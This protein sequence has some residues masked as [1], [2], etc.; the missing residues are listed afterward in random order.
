MQDCREY[1]FYLKKK[2]KKRSEKYYSQIQI[3]SLP[4]R[5]FSRKKIIPAWNDSCK[6]F[7]ARHKFLLWKC[8]GM[9]KGG[10]LFEEMKSSWSKI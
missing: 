8:H 5:C 3:N 4:F 7:Y 9:N 2:E 1:K 6:V 10:K